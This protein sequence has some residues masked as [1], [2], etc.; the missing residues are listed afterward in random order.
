[1]GRLYDATCGRAF[2]AW[3]GFLMR[4]IDE[5]G[6]R[7]TRSGLLA[8]ASGRV[9]DIGSGTGSNIPLYP[10]STELVLSEPDPH[11]RKALAAKLAEPGARPAELVGGPAEDLPFEDASFDCVVCT[12]V[13]CTMP[14]PE[15]GLA[16]VARVL[17]PGGRFLFLE[18]VRSEDA[19]VARVQDRLERPWR[20]VADGCHCNRDS[21]AM[22]E[23][24]PLEVRDVNTGEMPIAPPFMRPLIFG[25][26]VM[27]TA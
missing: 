1:M 21:L 18:H 9:L 23:A 13:L 19:K 22:I 20:F 2:T 11:M 5:Q 27:P 3:Y 14:K 16:E 4:R 24:S 8:G 10:S 7:Q 12:M 26:A 15:A 6:L 17:K 25:T